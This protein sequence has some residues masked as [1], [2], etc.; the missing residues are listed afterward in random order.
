[1]T[2]FNRIAHYEGK[3]PEPVDILEGNEEAGKS[4]YVTRTKSGDPSLSGI[5]IKNKVAPDLYEMRGKSSHPK[6]MFMLAHTAFKGV[7]GIVFATVSAQDKDARAVFKELDFKK[8]GHTRETSESGEQLGGEMI[9]ALRT[10]GNV[11][12]WALHFADIQDV[13]DMPLEQVPSLPKKWR[14]GK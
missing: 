8:M 3:L 12:S 1:M 2:K 5:L 6:G 4:V 7:D 11:G 13:K 9:F 10:K 14:D